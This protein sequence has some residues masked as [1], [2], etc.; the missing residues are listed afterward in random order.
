VFLHSGL[1]T[2]TRIPNSTK[3]TSATGKPV[4]L[5]LNEFKEEYV[6]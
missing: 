2:I 5:G 1:L 4:N 6:R 3:S